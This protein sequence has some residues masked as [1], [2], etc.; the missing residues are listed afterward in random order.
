LEDAQRFNA[1][2]ARSLA[3]HSDG[4]WFSWEAAKEAADVA[5]HI[6][7]PWL[8]ETCH[9]LDAALSES[10]QMPGDIEDAIEEECKAGI[11]NLSYEVSDLSWNEQMALAAKLSIVKLSKYVLK[12]FNGSDSAY[13]G[14]FLSKVRRL[15]AGDRSR[16][17]QSDPKGQT[18][19]S[20]RHIS[21][22]NLVDFFAN[23]SQIAQKP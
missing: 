11:D 6:D 21:S 22:K 19:W 4:V 18:K 3:T 2:W 5:V 15:A 7:E 1:I 14:F 20:L 9:L 10:T 8:T 23:Q 17:M 16:T 13:R 12:W